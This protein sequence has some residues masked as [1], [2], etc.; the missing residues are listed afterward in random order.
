MFDLTRHRLCDGLKVLCT[1]V[2]YDANFL[3]KN[4]I[5]ISMRLLPRMNVMLDFIRWAQ[6]RCKE[7]EATEITK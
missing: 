5:F 4:I 6:L 1:H 7:C 3:F 2:N